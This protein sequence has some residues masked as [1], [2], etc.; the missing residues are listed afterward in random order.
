MHK[1][2][3]LIDTPPDDDRFDAGWPAFLQHAEQMPGLVRETT[4]RV[5]FVLYGDRQPSLIHE[6]HFAS[7]VSLEQAMQSEHGQQ[8][9]QVLQRITGGR[10]S[11]FFADHHEDSA[12]NLARTRTEKNDS[13]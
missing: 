13:E 6:L 11:L 10:F 1:L 3:I 7:R 9:G 8:A 4:S 5:T 12:E 2:V